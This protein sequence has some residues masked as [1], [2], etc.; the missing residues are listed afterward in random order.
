MSSNVNLLAPKLNL[1]VKH[2]LALIPL[3][4][5]NNAFSVSLEE[6][7]NA[8]LA[9]GPLPCAELLD[10]YADN[11]GRF[12]GGLLDICSAAVPAGSTSNSSGGNSALATTTPAAMSR[13][14]KDIH[15][16]KES[17]D[18]VVTTKINPD[19]S[20]FF[21]AEIE[22]LDKEETDFS[23]AYDS[24]FF[25][26]IAG[27]TYSANPAAVYSFAI[28]AT[29]QDGDYDSGGDFENDSYGA[30][31]L[32]SF[33]PVDQWFI[34][35]LASI[36]SISA[37]YQRNSHFSYDFNNASVFSTSGAPAADYEY[38]LY[39]LNLEAGYDYQ[40]GRYTLTPSI[41]LQWQKT[42]YDTYSESGNTGLE[43]TF[44]DRKQT[45]LQTILGLTA[46]TSFSTNIGVINPQVGIAWHHELEDQEYGEVSFV[47]D[48]FNERFEYETDEPDSDFIT[49][50]AGAVLV[51]KQGLQGF[52]NVQTM[53][54][55]SY[56]D[57][58]IASLG[59][60]LEL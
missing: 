54:G 58:L 42:D 20:L 43:L 3:V 30:R 18:E 28:D 17:G 49:I 51:F 29:Q 34:S 16:G 56:Y 11:T 44:Y 55:H 38:D 40:A 2:L 19:W 23:G 35:A 14:V 13:V 32:A 1:S 60:R 47:G 4:V 39:G 21:T 53:A 15:A 7:V 48:S 31:L 8:Q 24:D 6:A 45:S 37:E 10:G 50:S 5:S 52:V 41:G 36:N 59:F 22:T 46:I 25:R 12:S 27:V 57:N 33:R 9:L 26:A